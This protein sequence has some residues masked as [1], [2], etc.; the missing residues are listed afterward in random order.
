MNSVRA[1]PGTP[2]AASL[3]VDRR[4]HPYPIQPAPQ[5]LQPIA[6]APQLPLQPLQPY[7]GD[8]QPNHSQSHL[9]HS[10]G[11][12]T[13]STLHS[14]QKNIDDSHR[15]LNE[16]PQQVTQQNS[17]YSTVPPSVI[18]TFSESSPSTRPPFYQPVYKVR[19]PVTTSY[20]SPPTDSYPFNPPIDSRY[21]INNDRGYHVEGV[22]GILGKN[23]IRRFPDLPNDEVYY[24]G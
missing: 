2:G 9:R 10:Y 16:Q 7:I 14:P 23:D 11:Q 24:T 19:D 22:E 21:T 17:F 15:G 3:P 8:G 6:P 13:P 4:Y 20:T 12:Q 1:V 18:S 5:T